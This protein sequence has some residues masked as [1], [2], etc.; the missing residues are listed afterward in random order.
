MA[1]KSCLFSLA[2]SNTK[3]KHDNPGVCVLFLRK[4]QVLWQLRK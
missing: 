3:Y 4:T 1:E 2:I